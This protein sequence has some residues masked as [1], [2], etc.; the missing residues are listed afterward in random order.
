M[1]RV[2]PVDVIGIDP[3]HSTIIPGMLDDITRTIL[4]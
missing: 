3:R 4:P 2:R 1:K